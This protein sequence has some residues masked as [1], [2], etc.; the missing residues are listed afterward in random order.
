M[1]TYPGRTVDRSGQREPNEEKASITEAN[2]VETSVYRAAGWRLA[3]GDSVMTVAG[4]VADV[5]GINRIG[6]GLFGEPPASGCM[7]PGSWPGCERGFG[8]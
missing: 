8:L 1:Q 7:T 3:V 4:S 2:H 5:D 6:R